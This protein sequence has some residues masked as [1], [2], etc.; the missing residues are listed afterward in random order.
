MEKLTKRYG[1]LTAICM[2]VGTVIGSGVF[3]KAQSVLNATNGN[4]PLGISAWFTPN[5]CCFTA[6][7]PNVAVKRTIKTTIARICNTISI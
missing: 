1:L 6:T 5:S 4:M 3:F 2:V 7:S